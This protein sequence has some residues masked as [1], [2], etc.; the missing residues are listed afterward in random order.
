MMMAFESANLIAREQ[1][2]SPCAEPAFLGR[3]A[4]LLDCLSTGKGLF[5]VPECFRFAFVLE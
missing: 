4:T 1:F 2:R 5:F 3:P